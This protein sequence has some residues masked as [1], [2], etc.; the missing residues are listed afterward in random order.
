MFRISP[1]APDMY[2]PGFA[3]GLA[4]KCTIQLAYAYCLVILC[5]ITDTPIGLL[6]LYDRFGLLARQKVIV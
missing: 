3:S 4:S 1:G 6:R 2:Y 5:S